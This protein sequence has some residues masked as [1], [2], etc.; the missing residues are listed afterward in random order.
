MRL[1][2]EDLKNSIRK[3]KKASCPTF[4]GKKRGELMSIVNKLGL[5][6]TATGKEKRPS[7]KTAVSKAVEL[8]QKT[9]GANRGK[10]KSRVEKAVEL[11]RDTLAKNTGRK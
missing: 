1:T 9:L 10:G 6:P 3:Y 11:A 8:A 7:K 4:S 5:K 2:N